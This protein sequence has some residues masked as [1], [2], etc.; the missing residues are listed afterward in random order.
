[1]HTAARQ[2][3]PWS[4]GLTVSAAVKA[5]H[6]DIMAALDAN[7]Y[8][9]TTGFLGADACAAMRLEAEQLYASGEFMQSVSTDAHGQRFAKE[10][11]HAVELDGDEWDRAA[12]LLE[13]TAQ[14]MATVP[15]ALN[16][17]SPE[18]CIS[19]A[20]YGTKLAVATAGCGS[21]YPKHVDNSGSPDQRK[22]TM[23]YY[24][25]PEWA[26]AMGGHLRLHLGG[27]DDE[28]VDISPEGDRVVLFWS[29][30]IV[31]E[32]LPNLAPRGDRVRGD[33]YA[34][35]LW[36]VSGCQS[37]ICDES[38]PAWQTV[39]AHFPRGDPIKDGTKP[40]TTQRVQAEAVASAVRALSGRELCDLASQAGVAIG[41]VGTPQ[42]NDAAEGTDWW[43]AVVTHPTLP[44]SERVR[45]R[46]QVEKDIIQILN[47]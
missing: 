24:L 22:L 30:L 6:S 3:G 5:R 25:N 20:A 45:G 43:E 47:R 17:H 38:Q 35:T 23:I 46:E 8:Y 21:K 7:G 41:A 37:Q 29:D 13:Y 33:R 36:L 12:W 27:I 16:S 32:V 14:V 4:D 34:L 42:D 11:V 18:L 28:P 15:A 2:V 19:E 10:G 40:S 44:P 31:H 39:L 26:P 1:M 9:T